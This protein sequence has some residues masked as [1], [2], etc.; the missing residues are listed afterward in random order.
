M[1]LSEVDQATLLNT[2]TNPA[3]TPIILNKSNLMQ[4]IKKVVLAFPKTKNG[5]KL[6]GDSFMKF[7]SNINFEKG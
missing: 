5:Q 3:E 6:K 7:G 1:T 4:Y 2:G